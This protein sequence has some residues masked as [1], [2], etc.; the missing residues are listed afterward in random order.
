MVGYVFVLIKRVKLLT[1]SDRVHMIVLPTG[2]SD[3]R[4]VT[5]SRPAT[6]LSASMEGVLSGDSV[7]I[8]AR[9]TVVCLYGVVGS[10]EIYWDRGGVWGGEGNFLILTD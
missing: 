10:N 6:C 4:K 7:L 8:L 9:L 3:R 1:L 2:V 5:V